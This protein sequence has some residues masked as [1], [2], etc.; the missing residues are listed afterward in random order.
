MTTFEKKMGGFLIMR[1]DLTEDEASKYGLKNETDE[2]EKFVSANTQ[3]LGK[4]KWLCPLSGK[5]FKG[6]DF[7][8]KHILQKHTEKVDEVKKEVNYF[9]NC[10]KDPKRPQLPENPKNGSENKRGGRDSGS[11]RSGGDPY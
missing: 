8:R 3:E 4:D 7:V 9:N 5:K 10:L 11:G 2:V 6:P 1:G